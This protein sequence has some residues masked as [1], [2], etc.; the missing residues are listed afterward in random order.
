MSQIW[1]DNAR[2]ITPV[3][4]YSR[5]SN[6]GYNQIKLKIVMRGTLRGIHDRS[7]EHDSK[8]SLHNAH[9]KNDERYLILNMNI[10]DQLTARLTNIIH[11]NQTYKF[12]Y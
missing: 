3:S 7:R 4:E 9:I 11:M 2:N 1:R 6:K 10:P 12:N 5:R 8:N